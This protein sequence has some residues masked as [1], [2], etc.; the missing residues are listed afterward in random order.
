MKETI[1]NLVR[2]FD[3]EEYSDQ[4]MRGRLRLNRLRYYKQLEEMCGDGRGNY[5]EAPAAWWQKT[6]FAIEFNDHPALNIHTKIS[7]SQSYYRLSISIIS[8]SYA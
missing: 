3:K 1:L 6:H 2:F 7:T 5:A 8:A 4:F